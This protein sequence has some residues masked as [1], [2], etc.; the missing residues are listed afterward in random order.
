MPDRLQMC[1]E[2]GAMLALRPAAVSPAVAAAGAADN[3]QAAVIWAREAGRM[4]ACAAVYAA[5]GKPELEAQ[6]RNSAA[7]YAAKAAEHW[8]R[9]A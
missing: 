3:A 8:G 6:H 7:L 1:R 9:D 2:I 4:D 5:L